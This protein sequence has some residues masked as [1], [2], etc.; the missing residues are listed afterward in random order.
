MGILTNVRIFKQAIGRHKGNTAQSS[1]GVAFTF[2]MLFILKQQKNRPFKE[3]IHRYEFLL[4]SSQVSLKRKNSDKVESTALSEFLYVGF[5]KISPL[6][7][8]CITHI[9]VQRNLG[10][11]HMQKY[12]NKLSPY[13]RLPLSIKN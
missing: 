6:T 10:H 4:H 8:Y 2:Y 12:Y 3:I 5:E 9:I 7:S 1:C 11:F 13:L